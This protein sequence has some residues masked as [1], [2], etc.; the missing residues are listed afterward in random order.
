MAA[1]SV[2]QLSWTTRLLTLGDVQTHVYVSPTGGTSAVEWSLGDVTAWVWKS[3]DSGS[4]LQKFAKQMDR[5]QS[6]YRTMYGQDMPAPMQ[7]A[8]TK[9]KDPSRVTMYEKTVSTPVL[10]STLVALL[11]LPHFS[12]DVFHRAA[13]IVYGLLRRLCESHHAG[14]LN[15]PTLGM[16][17]K[18]V[19]VNA[20][21]TLASSDVWSETIR[22]TL[23]SSWQDSVSDTNLAWLRSTCQTM[24]I[25]E[26]ILFCLNPAVLQKFSFLRIAGEQLMQQVLNLCTPAC[27]LDLT[28]PSTLKRCQAVGSTVAVRRG[29]KVGAYFEA[30]QMICRGE[31]FDVPMIQALMEPEYQLYPLLV[32][33]ADCGHAGTARKRYYVIMRHVASTDCIFDPFELYELIR[34]YITER[35][36]LIATAEEVALEAQAV[37]RT[38]NLVYNPNEFDLRYLLNRREVNSLEKACAEYWARFGSD[39]YSDP[40]LAIYLGDS[41]DQWLTWSAVSGRTPTMRLN[42]GL[43]FFPCARRWMCASERLAALGMPI[44]KELAEP[45]GIPRVLIRDERRANF[46]AGNCMLLPSVAIVQMIALACVAAKQRVFFDGPNIGKRPTELLYLYAPRLNLGAVAPPMAAATTAANPPLLSAAAVEYL[47]LVA[48]GGKAKA[49]APGKYSSS[50]KNLSM[51][52]DHLI[53]EMVGHAE[54]V[55]CG[56]AYLNKVGLTPKDKPYSPKPETDFE[57]VKAE[58]VEQL[59][60]EYCRQG[61]QVKQSKM[62]KEEAWAKSETALVEAARDLANAGT[63]APA[64]PLAG[65]G[66]VGL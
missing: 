51:F 17:Q 61:M 50:Y 5:I 53:L 11:T 42:S 60:N 25:P 24:T 43:M 12:P 34:E 52:P 29:L 66:G 31:T 40:N 27:M 46:L 3:G 23:E 7:L 55:F 65:I 20:S 21:G 38:R 54:P 16:Q 19:K 8:Q 56:S 14:T 35:D 10:A 6:A 63:A 39:P 18:R 37:A 36:Y 22:P 1:A 2:L 30:C 48:E 58:H 13:E 62:T 45:M 41:G 9:N 33:S 59:K 28:D 32:D 4:R 26:F 57:Y 49:K 47:N 44:R 15:V 64:Q